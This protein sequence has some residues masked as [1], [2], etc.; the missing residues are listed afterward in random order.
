ME[1]R[2]AGFDLEREKFQIFPCE[3]PCEKTYPKSAKR[4]EIAENLKS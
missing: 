2:T 3:N 4:W 1:L